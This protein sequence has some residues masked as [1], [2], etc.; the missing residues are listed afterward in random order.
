MEFKD[1]YQILGVDKSANA[2]DVKK[3]YRKLARK[4]HPDVSKEPDAAARMA[5]VNE[6]NAVL[7]D[8]EKRAAYDS[9]GAQSWAAG[10]RPGDDVRPPPGWNEG[11]EF[12]GGDAD[13]EAFRH[14][15][16]DPSGGAAG[17]HSDFF[18]QLFGRAARAHA[19]RRHGPPHGPGPVRGEDRHARIE[20]ELIDA[21]KGAERGIALHG[22]R[23]DAQG[24]PVAEERTLQVRIPQGVKEGQLIRLAGHGGPGLGGGAAGDLFLEVHFRPDTRWRIEGRDVTQRL[25]VTPW[26][27]SL[28]GGVQVA[29]PDGAVVEVTV[30]AGSGSG[31]KLRL[32]GR[33]I[34]SASTPG[35]LYLELDIAVP[36]AIT[37][38]Q[39][40]AWSALAAAYPGFD[41][42]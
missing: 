18:E 32:K 33:G 13:A 6:A 25:R 7:S 28:G 19:G 3:A 36:G 12:S 22:V 41:P 31:R 34:P 24:R 11:F 17:E 21:Y 26:E 1:Y 38:A 8:P 23:L 2:D 35:D 42:R 15:F 5:E 14:A 37:D 9:V 29:T 20:L 16:H 27:A 30:P 40:A 4:Y 39:K 10:A